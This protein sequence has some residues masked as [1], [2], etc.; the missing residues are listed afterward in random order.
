MTQWL[1][2][3]YCGK[4]W[5]ATFYRTLPACPKCGESKEIKVYKQGTKHN[6]Y[7]EDDPQPEE[8][9]KHDYGEY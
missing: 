5:Q 2:C 3:K 7:Y 1:E 4:Q 6:K 8:K 9:I